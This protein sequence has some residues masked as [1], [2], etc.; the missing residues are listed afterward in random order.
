MKA[1]RRKRPVDLAR[2]RDAEPRLEALLT[3][4]P[5]LAERTARYLAGELPGRG[6]TTMPAPHKVVKLPAALFNEAAR[7][8]P[9]LDGRPELAAAGR[10]STMAVVRWAL[11]LGLAELRRTAGT[12]GKP[13]P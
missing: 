13:D 4:H 10:P 8:L 11:A 6:E 2:A 5:E 3:A 1:G 12:T 9:L 7:L